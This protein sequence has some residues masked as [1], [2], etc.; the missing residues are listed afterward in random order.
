M[1]GDRGL[2]VGGFLLLVEVEMSYRGFG[3]RV[4]SKRCQ[5]T[6]IV[7]NASQERM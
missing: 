6:A 4:E 3:Y 5:N 2:E 1:V 7:L